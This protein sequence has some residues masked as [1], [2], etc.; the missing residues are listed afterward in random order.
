MNEPPRK[1]CCSDIE[2]A[3]AAGSL[4]RKGLLIGGGQEGVGGAALRFMNGQASA[5]V[6]TENRSSADSLCCNGGRTALGQVTSTRMEGSADPLLSSP[7]QG[8]GPCGEAPFHL[9]WAAFGPTFVSR[10]V[11][12]EWDSFSARDASPER[13]VHPTTEFKC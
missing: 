1:R 4:P 9:P 3:S 5:I 7:F 10:A 12:P 6:S 11:T 8:E 13:C 2:R